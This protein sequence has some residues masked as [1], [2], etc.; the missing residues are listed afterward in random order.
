MTA[1][2]RGADGEEDHTT[3]TDITKS[4]VLY[5]ALR[6]KA[7]ALGP[8]DAMA[9]ARDQKITVPVA[10][11][12]TPVSDQRA[13]LVAKSGDES[14]VEAFDAINADALAAEQRAIVLATALAEGRP[15]FTAKEEADRIVR[16]DAGL[17][18]LAS[19][20]R[21]HALGRHDDAD[22]FERRHF[23]EIRRARIDQDLHTDITSGETVRAIEGE[24]NAEK[25]AARRDQ[26]A[27]A[28]LDAELAR[29]DAI[30]DEKRDA[31][32][33]QRTMSATAAKADAW[34]GGLMCHR[35]GDS[36]IFEG[37]AG[38]PADVLPLFP[39]R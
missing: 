2:A 32:V 11:V 12:P 16:G 10:L 20:E 17:D 33:S 4:P 38:P 9:W 27:G 30:Y 13:A 18:P 29:I 35:E 21:L 34:I 36:S 24:R 5:E 22:F 39:R 7:A 37:N 26:R 14:A 6:A 8:E 28:A 3:M 19:L 25:N 31:Y 15:A 23:A 1:A